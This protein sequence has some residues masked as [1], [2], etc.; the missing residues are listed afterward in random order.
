MLATPRPGYGSTPPYLSREGRPGHAYSDQVGLAVTGGFGHFPGL[1]TERTVALASIDPDRVK[2]L[3]SAADAVAFFTRAEPV[4]GPVRPDVRTWLLRISHAGRSR[5][6]T[7]AEPFSDP[8]L[9]TL[10]RLAR[11]CLRQARSASVLEVLDTS[12][13][14]DIEV[15]F[16]RP[17]GHPRPATFD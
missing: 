10:V 12:R 16:D 9:V 17:V 1:A 8:G 3:L 13:A 4:K 2:A 5:L 6:L 14:G 7:L 11:D 15:S